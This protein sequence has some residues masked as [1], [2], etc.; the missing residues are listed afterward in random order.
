MLVAVTFLVMFAL[1]ASMIFLVVTLGGLPD[2]IARLR[3][4]PR[5]DAMNVCGWLALA[6]LGILWP[7]A[8]IRS[9]MKPVTVPFIAAE[10]SLTKT[11]SSQVS[12]FQTKVA[13]LENKL[14]RLR[15]ENG[16][17]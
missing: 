7:I 13:L 11:L 3:D 10:S 14:D 9:C 8:L 4:R 1:A 2:K 12:E 15:L 6:T 5:A 17:V 16:E